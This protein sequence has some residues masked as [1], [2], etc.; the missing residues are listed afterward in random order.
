MPRKPPPLPRTRRELTPVHILAMAGE[1]RRPVS[2]ESEDGTWYYRQEPGSIGGVAWAVWHTPTGITV[3]PR[4]NLADARAATA[5]GRALRDVE[6]VQAH[7]RGEHAGK[8]DALCL[9]C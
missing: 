5:D 4:R 6:R 3:T 7:L 1:P 9:S 8:R 2:A